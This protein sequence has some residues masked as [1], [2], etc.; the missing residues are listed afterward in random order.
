[1]NFKINHFY[2]Q[3]FKKSWVVVLL[4]VLLSSIQAFSTSIF[5]GSFA[6]YLIFLLSV[7]K[8]SAIVW[9]SFTQL[10]KIIGQSHLIS[11]ILTLF[12]FL[13]ATIVCSFSLDYLSLYVSDGN[14]FKT[15]LVNND[16][17]MVG[18]LYEYFYFSTITFSSVGYG[19]IVPQSILAKGIVMIQVAVRFFVLVFGIANIN[20]IKVDNNT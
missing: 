11:H 9:L 4:L 18:M 17:S 2:T 12:I 6:G 15:S 13:I 1:M 16:V 8:V 10:T 5:N 19:D 14:S 3:L 20:Q 7:L